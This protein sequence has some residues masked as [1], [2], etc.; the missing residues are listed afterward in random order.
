MDETRFVI[1]SIIDNR[2]DGSPF[3]NWAYYNKL[4]VLNRYAGTEY[5]E[6]VEEFVEVA[7]C[8]SFIELERNQNLLFKVTP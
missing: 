2:I 4:A 1:V 8:G 5:F 7:R 3:L 6:E